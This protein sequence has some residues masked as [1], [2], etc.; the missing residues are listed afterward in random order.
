MSEFSESFQFYSDDREAASTLLR[1]AGA[2]G[3]IAARTAH[4]ASF[5]LDDPEREADVIA[6]SRGVLARY[7]YGEDHG[8]W[9]NFY[10]DGELLTKIALVWD[11]EAAVQAPDAEPESEQ[12]PAPEPESAS[13]VV[14]KLA[15]AGVLGDAEAVELCRVLESFSPEDAASR[16]HAVE[17][18][19]RLLG[20]AAT[21]WLSTA[22]VQGSLLEEINRLFPGAEAVEI[23]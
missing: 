13:R 3:L 4:C 21:T 9:V 23:A 15:R 16:E 1:G 11:P 18:V 19:P 6:A 20:F 10:R 12:D 22:Y 7:F 5:V 14:Q 2:S 8:L 17:A